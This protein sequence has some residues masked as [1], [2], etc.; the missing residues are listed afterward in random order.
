MCALINAEWLSQVQIRLGREED[1]PGLEWQGE[2]I[3]FRRLYR[4]VYQNTCDGKAC[5]WVAELEQTGIIGQV[6]VQF[7]SS[8]REL[9]DGETRAYVYGFRV[10]PAYR[11]S[12]VGTKLLEQVEQDLQKRHFHW[13]T[14]NV[15]RQNMGAQRFYK[16]NGY[17]IVAAEAGRWSYTDHLGTRREVDEPAWR[18]QKSLPEEISGS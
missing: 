13:V 3:H 1:L 4:Q 5:I 10:Q 8:R 16:R 6:F 7:S 2:Y 15:S 14:L 18:M 17:Q 12:G 11:G 9:A